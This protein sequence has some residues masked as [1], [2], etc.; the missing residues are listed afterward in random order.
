MDDAIEHPD[1]DRNNTA[2][3]QNRHQRRW[4]IAS[5]SCA[6]SARSCSTCASRLRAR[7]CHIAVTADTVV[8][9]GERR[10]RLAGEHADH[11]V[12]RA[13]IEA[14]AQLGLHGASLHVGT[15]GRRLSD[16]QQPGYTLAILRALETETTPPTR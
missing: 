2:H 14:A 15:L 11:Q 1:G 5:S 3:C 12:P 9:R 7:S 13:D 16:L 6:G 4:G 8:V 10:G